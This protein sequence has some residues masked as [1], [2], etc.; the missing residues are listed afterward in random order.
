M[1]HNN[2]NDSIFIKN[3]LNAPT[4]EQTIVNKER[5]KTQ[6]SKISR[7]V[8]Q[9]MTLFNL[10]KIHQLSQIGLKLQKIFSFMKFLI[11]EVK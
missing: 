10:M 1:L 11:L 8:H 5:K 6:T 3:V 9:Q 4:K 2:D 7:K